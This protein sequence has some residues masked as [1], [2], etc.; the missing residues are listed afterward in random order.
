MNVSNYPVKTIP[1]RT[2]LEGGKRANALTYPRMET[3]QTE[4]QTSLASAGNK[5]T[6]D[7]PTFEQ[8]IAAVWPK[9]EELKRLDAYKLNLLHN[10]QQFIAET[11][12]DS[13]R[14]RG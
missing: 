2:V 5:V 10:K 9:E 8:Q 1:S 14:I 13:A 4:R 3:A 6:C 7:I 11:S 12:L